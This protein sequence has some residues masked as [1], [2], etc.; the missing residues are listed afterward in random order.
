MSVEIFLKM[1]I[2]NYDGFISSG[3]HLGNTGGNWK[4]VG[5]SFSFLQW[6]WVGASDIYSEVE[7]LQSRQI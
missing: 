2:T 4:T 1:N 3:D 6:K 7:F 5:S